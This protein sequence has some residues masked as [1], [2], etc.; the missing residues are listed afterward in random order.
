MVGISACGLYLPRYRLKR[1]T[2]FQAMG[3][4]NPGI[5]GMARGEKAIANYDEDSLTMAVAA[6]RDSFTDMDRAKIDALY[7]ASTTL[8]YKERGNAAILNEALNLSSDV[9]TSEYSGPLKAGTSALISA[10][11][12]A[13][14]QT[15]LVCATDCRIGKPGGN[16]E[17]L[18]GDGAAAIIIG[19]ERIIATFEG[20]YSLSYDFPDHRRIEGDKF[21]RSWEERWVREEGYSKTIMEVF[22]SILRKY[23]LHLQDIAKVVYPPL[24]ARDHGEMAKSLGLKPE[25][26][27]SS[28]IEEMGHTG[29]AHPF[30]MLI[31]ALEEAKIG[32]KILTISYG[33]GGDAL[34]FQ[35]TEEIRELKNRS[36]LKNQL[37][38][39]EELKG[40]EKYLS[41]RDVLPKE[42]G[43]RGEEIAPTSLSLHWRERK[44]ILGL[45]GFKCKACGTPQ[46]P[47]ERICINPD[48]GAIDQMEDYPF[49]DKKGKL[50]TYTGDNLTFSEDPPALYGIVDFEGGGRY[51]FD[52]TDCP[53]ETLKVGQAVEMTFRRKYRD[54]ARSLYGYFWKAMPLRE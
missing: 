30:I 50:F 9:R 23:G 1:E 13:G 32:D 22:H 41:F 31:G 18:C 46:F 38:Q 29:C 12:E 4:F 53:L 43:I 45:F 40:Y 33:G 6:G 42:I 49:S 28:L 16:Q 5:K 44:S 54:R 24:S 26:I 35:V 27:Q 17:A 37:S 2:L 21:N 20:H 34:L 39:K 14:S 7:L 11:N 47:Q 15:T 52:I 51:W 19:N 25:Q 10:L 36:K 48:C 3:W 8:P